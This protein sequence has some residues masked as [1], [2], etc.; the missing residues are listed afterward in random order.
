M[1]VR[2]TPNP[3]I[4]E[5]NLP[6]S[7]NFTGGVEVNDVLHTVSKTTA[8]TTTFTCTYGLTTKITVIHVV[9]VVSLVPDEADGCTEIDDGDGDP[10]TKAYAVSKAST[11]VVTVRA[12]PNP[13][14]GEPNLPASWSFTGGIEV[15]D[16]VHTVSKT[17]AATATF[18]CTCGSSAKTTV[19]YVV[20][21]D[22]DI[23]GVDDD[24][25]VNPGGF[26]AL[27]DD[28]DN[29]NGVLDKDDTD[30]NS[31]ED[32]LVKLEFRLLP[33]SLPVGGSNPVVLQPTAGSGSVRIYLN[34][35]KSTPLSTP[36]SVVS[37][38][39]LADGV[40]V[41]GY[42]ASTAV[43]DVELALEYSM[44]GT[45][46]DD[47][48]DMTVVDANL[49][50]TDLRGTVTEPNDEDPG[51]FIHFNLDNDDSSDNS[52]QTPK[53]PG[54]DYANDT[55]AV[56]GEDD[57]LPLAIQLSPLLSEGTVVLTNTSS[58]E[59]WKTANKGTGN[60]LLAY[61]SL[62]WNLADANKRNEFQALCASGVYTEGSASGGGEVALRYYGPGGG[63]PIG[64]DKVKYTF[65]AADCGNQPTTTGTP[66]QRDFLEAAF[67]DLVRCEWSITGGATPAY[68]CIAWSAGLSDRWVEPTIY[69]PGL[70]YVADRW[71]SGVHYVSIDKMY[72]NGNDVF[73]ISDLDAFYATVAGVTPTA[74]DPNDATVMYYDGYHGAK[75]KTCGCGLG[76]WIVYESK[77]GN[78]ERIE[79]C[80]DQLDNS[81]AGYG[82][83]SRYYK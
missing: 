53:R 19:V 57:L 13:D 83:R 32:D 76:Q 59:L 27:N 82:V 47:R 69:V 4:G 56:T 51:A 17:T 6:A 61:G 11:G 3:D 30:P 63:S 5:P 26:I 1:A 39:A 80:Y 31:N 42:S 54:A 34:G 64:P 44:G 75:K 72:G 36:L 68:N 24:D 43:R 74:S 71:Q 66:S 70:G 2:A 33:E 62:S 20:E 38:E 81:A 35:D 21:I 14:V 9:E 67:G 8:G 48:I 50:A 16:V 10:N 52:V 7:W 25:E 58:G 78:A 73:E 77:C 41:E 23:T 37:R 45:T 18:T 60:L 28:D 29:A 79:H 65:I 12:T 22:L 46:F 55:T 40:W 49:T 15:N